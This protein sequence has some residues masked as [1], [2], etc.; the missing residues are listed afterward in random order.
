MTQRH[1]INMEVAPVQDGKFQA[2]VKLDNGQVATS[3]PFES[4]DDASSWAA[5]YA[6][7]AGKAADEDYSP[8]VKAM[9]ASESKVADQS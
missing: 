6:E 5:K 3:K 4:T 1:L 8:E 7:E 9:L 2:T